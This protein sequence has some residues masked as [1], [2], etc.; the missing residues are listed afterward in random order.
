MRKERGEGGFCRERKKKSYEEY[1][2]MKEMKRMKKKNKLLVIVGKN[3]K[4]GTYL[5]G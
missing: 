1:E 3:E 2:E 4:V 5:I